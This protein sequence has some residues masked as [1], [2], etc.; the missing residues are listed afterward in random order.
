MFDP[1]KEEITIV[2]EHR[3]NRKEHG[4][5]VP[6]TSLVDRLRHWRNHPECW[7]CLH[8]CGHGF[9]TYGC[10]TWQHVYAGTALLN[11]RHFK[12]HMYLQV[13]KD[14]G[15]GA[16]RAVAKKL[17]SSCKHLPTGDALLLW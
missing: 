4:E 13:L 16:Y 8:H 1:S 17:V 15:K 5:V 12:F 10:D 11:A 9:T 2:R 3:T 7:L 6:L 14:V